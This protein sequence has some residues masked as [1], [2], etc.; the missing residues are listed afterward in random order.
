[1]DQLT[2]RCQIIP[3]RKEKLMPISLVCPS[4]QRGLRVPDDLAGKMV[5]CPQCSTKFVVGD[6]VQPGPV[7]GQPHAVKPA[8]PPSLPRADPIA[9]PREPPPLVLMPVA[10]SN[11]ATRKGPPPPPVLMP[12]A[13]SAASSE[14]ARRPGKD[15]PPVSFQVTVKSDSKKEFKWGCKAEV[16]QDGLWIRKGKKE[17]LVPVGAAAE[18]LGRNRLAVELENGRRLELVVAKFGSYLNRLTEDV[19]KY[20][21]GERRSMRSAGYRL[22]WYLFIPAVLPLAIPILTLGGAIPCALGF[23][24]AGACFAIAQQDRWPIGARLTISITLAILAYAIMAVLIV[25][26]LKTGVLQTR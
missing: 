8:A 24:A 7:G 25:V 15:F 1:M 13:D 19:V 3:R 21:N 5:R 18:H 14:P 26:V 9:T 2:H 22:E 6:G 4:C 12:V 16:D 20:L 10:D 17:L 23:G 11:T